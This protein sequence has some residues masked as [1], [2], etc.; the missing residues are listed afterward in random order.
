[1]AM[2]DDLQRLLQQLMKG[3]AEAKS[4]QDLEQLR[5]RFFGKKGEL[6][7]ALKQMGQ[8]TPEERPRVGQLVNTIRDQMQLVLSDRQRVLGVELMLAKLGSEKIDLTLPGRGSSRGSLHPLT[9][10]RARVIELFATMGFRVAE[11]PEIEDEFHNFEALNIP[12]N[13]PARAM[14]DTFYI[15]AQY[16]LRTQTSPVQ[17]REMQISGAPIRLIAPGRVYRRDSD[18]THTPMFHQ[19]EGLLVDKSCSFGQLKGLLQD[20]MRQFFEEDLE[21]RFR[22]SYFPFTE[23]S[24]EVDIRSPKTGEWLEVLG[25]GMVHPNVLRQ[26]NV[27]PEQYIGFAFGI[28]LD[29]LAMLYYGIPDLRMM[30]TNDLHFLQ[31]F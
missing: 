21:L 10:V 17:I 11:G 27:D 26:V 13:H 14:Q 19:V 28:G 30:F 20:F 31:Q 9:H 29:R 12:A 7:A 5:I 15:D 24:A 16:L 2:E 18:Q 22:P 23:P 3:T 1:M 25:C 4:E 6:T 8:L